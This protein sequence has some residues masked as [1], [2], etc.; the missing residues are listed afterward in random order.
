MSF[1]EELIRQLDTVASL[2]RSGPQQFRSSATSVRGVKARI[3]YILSPKTGVAVDEVARLAGV[4][5]RTV[6]AWQRGGTP[7]KAS[8]QK[9]DQVYQQFFGIRVKAGATKARAK[10]ADQVLSQVQ[11]NKLWLTNEDDESRPWMA[12]GAWAQFV[13][14]WAASDLAGLDDAWEDIVSSWDYP[15]PWMPD[16]IVHIAIV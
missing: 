5:P 10:K 12:K 14:L 11:R 4:T 8:K 15:E 16:L 7:S 6:R 1:G 9:I 13:R 2:S 3:G